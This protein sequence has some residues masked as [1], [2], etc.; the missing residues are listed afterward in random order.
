[1]DQQAFINEYIQ[2][3]ANQCKNLLME[4][5]MLGVQH[6]MATKQIEEQTKNIDELQKQIDDLNRQLTELRQQQPVV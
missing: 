6:A 2:Q 4:K 1:M 3:L 5:T